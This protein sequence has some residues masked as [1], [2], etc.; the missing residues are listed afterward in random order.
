MPSE[1][2]YALMVNGIPYTVT[3]QPTTTLLTV[4]RDHLGLTGTKDGC[5]TGHCG[6]CMIHQNGAPVRACLVPMRRA[7]GATITTIEGLHGPSGGLHPVQQAYIE[8][9][10]VQCGFCTPGFIMSSIALLERNP[11][12]SL[13]Q[14]YAA[15]RWNICRCTGHNA[16]IRAIQAAAGQ[17][18]PPAPTVQAPMRVIATAVPRPDALAKVTGTG[19]YAAD[20]R[21]PG[22]LH[23]KV[24]RSD[25]PHANLLKLE[26]S[27]ARALPG[28]IAVLTAE[29][30]PGR[31]DCGVHEIDWPVLCYD[32]VRYVGDALALVIAESEAIAEQAVELIT[33]EYAPLPIVV[34]PLEAF[35]P[36]APLVHEERPDGN[37][38]A[39]YQLACGDLATGFAQ[40]EV[41]VEREYRT[42]TVEHAFIEPEAGLAVPEPAGRITVYCGGQIPFGDRRQI[43]ATLN[44]PEE[45]IRVV[46]ALIGGA[47]GGKE[48]VTV[49]ILTAL[50]AYVTGRPVR[51]VFSR[52]ESLRVHPK[53]HATIIKMKT[54][55]TRAGDLVAHEVTIYGDGGA[56]ASLS[57]H[58]MLR[59]TTHAAGPY[60]IPNVA[61]QTH[62]LYTNNVP[63]GAFR[64]FGVTQSGFAVESQLD[65]LAEALGM[66]PLELRRRNLLG[67]GKA[68]L[69]GQVIEESCGLAECVDLVAREVAAHPVVAVEGTKR[70]A[71]GFACAYKNTGYGSGAYDAAGAE[72]EVLA[73]GRVQVRAGA[74]E[75]GQGL[76]TVLAQIA[77]EELGLPFDQVTVLLADTDL[78]L[79]GQATTAS[80]QTFVTGNATRHA[81]LG[82]RAM[83]AGTAAEL[84]DVPP[85]QLVF[86]EGSVQAN[87][88]SIAL[89]ELADLCRQEGQ[90]PSVA[91]T[92]VTPPSGPYQHIAFGFAAQA[93][94]VEVDLTT[95]ETKVLRVVAACDVGRALNPLGLRGQVEGSISMGLGMALQ[96]NFVMEQGQVKTDTLHKCKLPTISQ[97][98]EITV[99][100]VEDPTRHGPYG[101]KGVG[102]L[103]SI[104]TAPAIINAIA[105]ATGVRCYRLPADKAWLK[106]QLREGSPASGRRVVRPYAPSALQSFCFTVYGSPFPPHP[107]TPLPLKGGGGT[108]A[109]KLIPMLITNGTVLTF[110]SQ[111]Q[112][113]SPGAVAYAADTILAVGPAAELEA[114]YPEFERLDAQGKLI[115]PG[116]ICAHTHFYGAFARGMA[117]PGPAPANFMQVLE[118]LWWRLDRA[119]TLE[120]CRLSALVCLADAIRGGV[121]TLIDHHASPHAIDGS[122]DALAAA[123]TLAGLRVALC[124][125]VTDRNGAS[126][127]AAGLA[128]N[129]RW[130]RRLQAQPNPKLGAAVGLHASFTC[131]DATLE[132]CAALAQDLA[133]PIHIHLA[134]DPADQADSLQRSGMRATQRL[135]AYGLLGPKTLLAH[136]I[137]VDQAELA[138]IKDR[139]AMVSHQPRS[140]MNN[141]VGTAPVEAMLELGITL[142]LGNDGFSNNMFSEI[143]A[144][145]LLHRASSGDPRTLAGDRLIS[146]A[147]QQNAQIAQHFFAPRLGALAAG[148]AADIILLDYQPYTP[149]TLAN[150]PWHMIF[151][152][153][154]RQ[155]THTICGGQLVM[156]DRELLTLDEAALAAAA[157]A[158]APA[159]WQRVTMLE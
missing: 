140:N 139:G 109:K 156:R 65:L 81:A 29:D 33:V 37:R 25:Q 110:G 118:R 28:V 19:Q 106:A 91:Y 155:V 68:T 23:A 121:T 10:A 77:S 159:L 117:L 123:A 20:L 57:A 45:Q 7:A 107:P 8:H 145:Y 154:G 98:P 129:A 17:P 134:E 67:Y 119:L 89:A 128:E 92:Y 59:A 13:D 4:L 5:A 26:T 87:G 22:M 85:D 15:H 108:S 80:R 47:F 99:H 152:L 153:D 127:T 44:L 104:P 115:M 48:D 38:L 36:D 49:Q 131:D 61:V 84:L 76:P 39:H 93:A 122:L 40:A 136:A 116:M 137:H 86:A 114:A 125:E 75:I 60:A 78:T 120:D 31:K 94:L 111:P 151:G 132:A 63:A 101:A 42:Q 55:A 46:N 100:L 54:G 73:D 16:I 56:Y 95:G 41:I 157:R 6:S 12:P 88:R 147:M 138:L 2:T 3:A 105:T 82:L 14:I 146:M 71:W 58:V 130:L 50:G 11:N 113:I 112:L 70:R 97:T 124:Y 74:A 52:A 143:Q 126:G 79:D 1:P 43:A 144:A 158:A 64:G 141:A 53:R 62:A 133:A 51:M 148:A 9:G 24:R 135:H 102:E 27:A 83:L 32:K 35:A 69:A 150:A 34:G 30:I 149:L 21:V 66:S 103:N 18:L 142:G 96:E 90:Q 72:V